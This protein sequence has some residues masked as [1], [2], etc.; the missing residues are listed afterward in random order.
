MIAYL[1]F[2]YA[3]GNILTAW[4]VGK[5]YGVDLR[6]ERSGNLGAR[7]AGATL[8]KRAFILTF[9]GDAGKSAIAVM[10]G[11]YFGFGAQGAALGA[12]M[13]VIGHIFPVI[14]RGRGG[15][16]VASLIGAAFMLNLPLFGIMTG[17][18]LIAIG[19]IKSATLSMPLAFLAYI[20]AVALTDSLPVLWPICAAM[21]I[22]LI[23]H[24]ADLQEVFQLRFAKL[25]K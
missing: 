14:L 3:L 6:Q 17:T 9:I 24:K 4:F 2:C 23:R 5:L 15:K 18:F 1:F 16:G 8:G 13:V 21:A 19:M 11:F 12:L 20:L 25:R 10:L 7:N 22:V